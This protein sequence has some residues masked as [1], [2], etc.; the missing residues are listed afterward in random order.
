MITEFSCFTTDRKRF[1]E[2]LR[3]LSPFCDTPTEIRG[4][5]DTG[6]VT[7]SPSDWIDLGL[8]VPK[9][10]TITWAGPP[11]SFIIL[12]GQDDQITEVFA[13]GHRLGLDY[14]LP[15]VQAQPIEVLCMVW[16]YFDRGRRLMGHTRLGWGCLFKGKGHDSFVSPRWL[17]HGPWLLQRYEPDITYVQLYD[18]AAE[19]EVA[20]QQGRRAMERLSDGFV[21]RFA[22]HFTEAKGSYSLEERCF[23]VLKTDRGITPFEMEHLCLIRAICRHH[24]T[25]PIERVRVTFTEERDARRHLGELWLREI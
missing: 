15:M 8:Q 17:E 6:E 18:L 14:F 11:E 12:R 24:A 2:E 13:R 16:D 4:W 3:K 23:S 20:W 21:T 9:R 5:P 19:G 25:Q 22:M 10:A 7:E 1:L